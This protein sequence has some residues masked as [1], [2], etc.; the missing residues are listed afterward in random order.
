MECLIQIYT[1]SLRLSGRVVMQRIV[2]PSTP[3]DS[4]LSLQNSFFFK[5]MK[6]F[7]YKWSTLFLAIKNNFLRNIAILKNYLFPTILDNHL[8]YYSSLN[9]LEDNWF[10]NLPDTQ[11]EQRVLKHSRH[12]ILFSRSFLYDFLLKIINIQKL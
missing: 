6:E 4:D 12:S 1:I 8:N 3:F 11:E 7:W 2:N 10:E 5:T 9:I